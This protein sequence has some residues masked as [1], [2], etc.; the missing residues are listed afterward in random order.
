[1]K[2]FKY[3]KFLDIFKA[4][5]N[6]V[7]IDY[8][9][10]R[11]ILRMKLLIDSRKVSTVLQNQKKDNKDDEKN[12]FI[13]SLGI[14]LLFGAF[15]CV[16]IFIRNNYLFSMTIV[17]SMFMFFIMTSLVSDFSSIIL[18]LKDK[19]IILTRPVN[20][21]TLNAAKVLH[22]F[23]YIFMITM[24]LLGPALLLSLKRYGYTFFLL[25]LAAAVL[26]DLFSIVL[27]SL[28]YLLILRFYSGEKLKDIINY[29]QIILTITIT[30]GYQFM[31]RIFTFIDLDNIEINLTWWKFFM[32]PLW[33]AAPFE[34]F[35]NG[36]TDNYIIGFS[37]LALVVP[38]VAII[39]YI[40]TSSVFESS[41]QKL[42]SSE[43]ETKNENK[44]TNYI[45]NLI[46]RDREEK[47][48]FKF[49]VNMIRNERTF[50]LKVYPSLGFSIIFPLILVFTAYING[51][52]SRS[53]FYSIYLAAFMVQD[54]VGFLSYSGNYKGAWIYQ[55]MPIVSKE[56]I[57]KG[58]LKAVF[59]N[60][61][62]PLY[63]FVSIVFLSIFKFNILLDLI[64]VYL[65]IFLLTILTHMI[66]EKDFPFSLAFETTERK[67]GFAE[68]IQ[69]LLAMGVLAGLH[70]LFGKIYLGSL[71]YLALIIVANMI[72]WKNGFKTAE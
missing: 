23:Y 51:A 9:V 41:L 52:L 30:I 28:L 71:I 37:L 72:F 11:K 58:A 19:E 61:F 4:L 18:D 13:K 10:L 40:K 16:F 47:T 64:I 32:P 48:F 25:F 66:Q 44:F 2:E 12:N 60:L 14:Y 67:N 45:S 56:A 34:L 69:V 46:C 49:T 20:S 55:T 43:G 21:R 22:I 29:F 65:N 50:K 38:V 26:I 6:K 57:H 15:L 35:I 1:M 27:T 63:I 54:V 3:L 36:N 70:F 59:T 42:R 39:T 68:L 7:G 5:F 24:A 31:S 62:T 33:F 53:S 17:F 8:P